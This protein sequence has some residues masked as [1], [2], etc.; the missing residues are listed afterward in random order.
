[1]PSRY[2]RSVEVTRRSIGLA[3]VP[4]LASL[5]S[6]SKVAQVLSSGPGGGITFPM[7]AG[8]PT[9]W[10]YVSLP[11]GPGGVSVG[12]PLSVAAFLPLFVLGLLLTSALEAGFLDS[13]ERRIDGRP[14]DF[15]DGVREFTLRMVGVNLV[16]AL[17][18]FMVFPLLFFPPLAL[19]VVI[20]LMYLVYGLPFEIVVRDIDLLSALEATVS[21]ALD[22]G[23]YAS[24]GLFHL[25]GGG[26]ASLLLTLVVRNGGIP[27]I[28][29]GVAV[30]AVPAVFVAVYGLFT[31][32]ELAGK[33]G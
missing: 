21:K 25:V 29:L 11:G 31:F 2:R 19:P 23:P 30:V 24:F 3:A 12:G 4:A 17:V 18:V 28:L 15:L 7:P 8:L 33:P 10:T 16:R 32:R 27:G 1:M 9:L 20:A 14:I 5:L 26:A 6:F 22:G 13:L